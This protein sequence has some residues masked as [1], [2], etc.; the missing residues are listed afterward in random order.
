ME[1]ELQKAIKNLDVAISAVSRVADKEKRAQ[2]AQYLTVVVKD[3]RELTYSL[4]LAREA[5][6]DK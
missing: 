5:F 4:S 2:C 1:I 3:M 6:F